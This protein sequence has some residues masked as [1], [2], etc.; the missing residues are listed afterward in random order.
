MAEQYDAEGISHSAD[1]PAIAQRYFALTKNGN[2]WKF[3]CPF[4][5]D[6][7]P[8]ATLYQKEGKWR[9]KCFACGES[10]DAISFVMA[11]ESCSFPD[12]CKKIT[13]GGNGH[14]PITPLKKAPPR[15][16][17]KPP[18]D[19]LPPPFATKQGEPS[20]L[21]PYLD[22]HSELLGYAADYG[23]DRQYWTW[24][25]RS[26]SEPPKWERKPFNPPVLFGLEQLARKPQAQVIITHDE[27]AAE[28]A[29][30]LFPAHAVVCWPGGDFAHSAPWWNV[31]AG[32]NSPP[33]LIPR[34]DP[35]GVQTMERLAVT[36]Y[37]LGFNEVKGINTETYD[38]NGLEVEALQGWSLADAEGW[39]P[40][41]ALEWAKKRRMVY[42]KPEAHQDMPPP[43]PLETPL[44]ELPA[45]IG[46]PTADAQQPRLTRPGPILGVVE[47][48]TVRAPKRQE[49]SAESDLPP[50]F[51]EDALAE[52]FTIGPGQDWRYT[53]AWG[54]WHRWT[55][56]RW[57][58]DVKK[59]VTWDART[60]C[61]EKSNDN[62]GELTKAGRQKIATLKTVNSVL[63]LAGSDPR[64]AT[65]PHEWDG[66]PWL[67]GTPG[68]VVD[69]KAGKLTEPDKAQFISKQ[70]AV[71]PAA[72]PAP[73]WASILART[74]AGDASYA[75]YLQRWAGYMLTGDTREECFLF[76]H[77][78]GGSGKST[79]VKVLTEIMGD[80]AVNAPIESFTASDRKEHS[81]EIARLAGARLVAANETED[82]AR[83]NESR[84][85]AL[86]GRDKIAARK[87]N[88]DFFEFQPQFKLLFI[89]N[90]KPALRSVGEEM[91][92]RIHLVNFPQ[93]IPE[94]ERD[95]GLKDKLVSEYPAILAWMIEG[96]M[97]W[98][99]YGLGQ[100]E[101]VQTAVTDYLTSED[102][103]GA[104]LEECCTAKPDATVP[105]GEAYKSFKSWAESVGEY[106]ISQ[107][108]FS[109]RLM[110]RGFDRGKSGVRYFKGLA[111]KPVQAPRTY[112]DR[113]E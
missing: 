34:N 36:L 37:S 40:T 41:Q 14:L 13:N 112:Q 101:Q 25:S 10:H 74:S 96:C 21:Y 4:H 52:A 90:H 59:Q 64:H 94:S 42:P 2:E 16:T 106:V 56:S 6:T 70:T 7:N 83:W 88:R 97:A 9:F 107:K 104:W 15:I 50:A 65:A 20:R 31:I 8:S 95:L 89:G 108:R 58:E 24:G 22:A 84:I 72:G 46:D 75:Q 76:V 28:A 55:G 38:N 54:V 110:D 81:T 66:D 113:D 111:L 79:F 51:S 91:K 61:R 17:A 99:D 60:V 19:C 109:Q 48:N 87:M 45:G 86:T 80:Y 103:L 30:P 1:L 98:Q 67:L 53:A 27:A 73:L 26:E 92:R 23:E 93:S 12:A 63:G 33:I 85:K 105:V 69:L 32:R 82:G 3:L 78:P 18:A 100:P 35:A 49:I 77:G 71:S 43:E 57:E 29:I 62:S 47:G 102:T 11:V 68:G 5:A 44:G 39:T